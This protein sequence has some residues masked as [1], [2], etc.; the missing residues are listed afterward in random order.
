MNLSPNF[1]LAE[2][3]WSDTAQRLRLDN[4]PDARITSHLVALAAGLEQIRTLLGDKPIR[5][6]SGYRSPSLN[7]AIGGARSSAHLDG[8]AA[9]FVCPAYSTPKQIAQALARSSLSF[10]Q[11]IQEGTWVHVSFAPAAR[12]QL[13]TARFTPAGTTYFMGV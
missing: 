12:R 11:V 2:L 10:D 3:T 5:I 4:R 8:Y 13:L 1:T 6:N 7:R 9:D